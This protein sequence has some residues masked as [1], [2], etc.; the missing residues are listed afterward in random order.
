MT[1]ETFEILV[2]ELAALPQESEWVEF[3]QNNSDPQKIGETISALANAAALHQRSSAFMV[4]GIRDTDHAIVGTDFQ[5]RKEKGNCLASLPVPPA[6]QPVWRE[7]DGG[8]STRQ[9]FIPR[10][11]AAG[12]WPGNAATG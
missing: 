3:K 4:W 7:G 2:K 1:S 12:Q 9:C 5:P 11:A 8:R 10:G 6:P